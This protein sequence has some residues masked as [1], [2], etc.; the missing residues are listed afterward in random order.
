[1]SSVKVL[2]VGSANGDLRNLCAKVG[3]M[4]AKHG[5]FDILIC[6]GNFFAQETPIEVIDELLENKLDFPITT[7]FMH[8]DNGVPGIIERTANRKN[9]EICNNLFYLGKHGTMKTA[10]SVKMASLSGSYDSAIYEADI[11]QEDFDKSLLQGRYTK[12]DVNALMQT[13]KP[14]SI[15]DTAKRGVDIFLSHEWPVGI[16]KLVGPTLPPPTDLP[17]STFSHP[18]ANAASALQPRYHF[19]ASSGKFWERAPYKNVH[20][21][22]HAT[23]FIALGDVGNKNK[24]RWFYA[25]NLVPLATVPDDVLTASVT[26]T[27]TDSPLA[28]A[29]ELK[30]RPDQ[31]DPAGFFWDP[32]R[33]RNEPPAGY[34]CH[35][36]NQ[37]G[38]FVKECTAER[39]QRG[40]VCNKCNF[41]GHLIKDC[42]LRMEEIAAREQARENGG[43]DVPP[44]GYLCK[45]CS[46]PG[47]YIKDCA[48]LKEEMEARGLQQQHGPNDV[49]PPDYTCVK[50]NTKGH[51][52]RNCSQFSPLDSKESE[53]VTRRK[54]GARAGGPRDSKAR[55]LQPCWFCLSNPDVDKNLIVSIGT[56]VYVAMSKGQLTETSPSPLVPGGGHVLLIGINH[57]SSFGK[58]DPEAL[59]DMNSE[60]RKYKEGLRKLYESKGAGMVT[61]ELSQGG[62][63]QHAH[64]Q[65]I[66]V[67]FEKMDE[68]ERE[69][70]A[71]IASFFLPS[72]RR[73]PRDGQPQSSTGGSSSSSAAHSKSDDTDTNG[74][75]NMEEA[76]QESPVS[77][78]TPTAA[79]LDRLPAGLKEGFFRIELPGERVMVCPIPAEQ[80]VDMQFGRTVLADVMGMPDRAHWKRCVKPADEER[81]DSNAFKT[82]FRTYDFTL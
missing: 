58:G 14:S 3:T 21:A 43:S 24:Q 1:M 11:E 33:V 6:T 62:I 20:G 65:V 35:R 38:H 30:R 68:V 26:P 44:S 29:S 52:V 18:V 69:F 61:L 19:A 59:S 46:Q 76:A 10:E 9:G 73:L 57:I 48:L 41:P 36:C 45:K 7:Y 79:W 53:S 71:R 15:M 63:N 47:H 27:T 4:Q 75:A 22:D 78:P 42:P 66:P 55:E 56:E 72:Y 51:Y 23:R 74:D 31:D 37:P 40:Y 54:P 39:V 64:I 12:Q 81:K 77:A 13:A 67:P 16:N 32:K 82:V 60:L 49:P 2:V 17:P 80:R 28:T 50:C 5:P 70:K 8:G 25:F 34:I